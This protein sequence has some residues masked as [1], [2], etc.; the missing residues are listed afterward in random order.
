M[1]RT[2]LGAWLVAIGTGGAL[3]VGADA[4]G[5]L[6]IVNSANP[7]HDVKR[8]VLSDMFLKRTTKWE[9]GTPVAAVDQSATSPVRE[10]FSKSVHK[11][12]SV[13]AYWQQQVFSGRDVP[14][15]VKASDD[16]VIAFVRANRGGV[17]YISPA[18]HV[19]DGVRPL[20]VG[21]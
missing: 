5:F 14:P 18:A 13:Q 4:G 21:E 11:Q 1:A 6:V 17:G 15:P 16:E 10:T 8:S 19:P 12:A 7:A 20:R 9:D 3:Q 2:I